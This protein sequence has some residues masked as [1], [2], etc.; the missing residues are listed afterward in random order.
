MIISLCTFVYLCI[1][2]CLSQTIPDL[3]SSAFCH[4]S[5]RVD[6]TCKVLFRLLTSRMSP[7]R[8][9]Q[10][11][12]PA[13]LATVLAT[14]TRLGC[15]FA[16]APETPVRL[17]LP[18]AHSTRKRVK[19]ASWLCT[20]IHPIF[21]TM[22]LRPCRRAPCSRD[23]LPHSLCLSSTSIYLLY[24]SLHLLRIPGPQ[25]VQRERGLYRWIALHPPGGVSSPLKPTSKESLPGGTVARF[26]APW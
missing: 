18:R 8:A 16:R 12:L 10:D 9:R 19:N 22:P 15:I 21:P 17:R 7:N 3:D 2:C 24:P 11:T 1:P 14:H 5:W 4:E 13:P 26:L 20:L 23:A 6:S 25:R